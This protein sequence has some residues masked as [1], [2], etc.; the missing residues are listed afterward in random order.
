MEKETR[1][2]KIIVP[3]KCPH[4]AKEIMVSTRMVTP[5]VDWVLRPEDI[6]IAKQAVKAEV[7]KAEMPEEEKK[8][9]HE[10]L[11]SPETL[12]GPEE[13]QLVVD[14]VLKKRS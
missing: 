3:G 2:V 8:M 14:Q 1:V 4:C 7:D 10:W 5:T 13:V 12:F 11:D 6:E 9:V